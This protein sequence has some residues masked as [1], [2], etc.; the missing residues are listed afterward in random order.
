MLLLL[1][2]LLLLLAWHTDAAA[3]PALIHQDCAVATS[4]MHQTLLKWTATYIRRADHS[5]RPFI[6]G[7]T[8][9][10]Y[11]RT[12]GRFSSFKR[13]SIYIKQV[14]FL[15]RNHSQKGVAGADHAHQIP[16]WIFLP[17]PFPPLLPS[18]LGAPPLGVEPPGVKVGGLGSHQLAATP[19]TSASVE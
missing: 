18:H 11:A 6:P 17:F 8:Q 15:S 19:D 12:Y 9:W 16:V 4:L 10:L 13:R 5:N 3:H 1:L 14:R 2:L 7:F